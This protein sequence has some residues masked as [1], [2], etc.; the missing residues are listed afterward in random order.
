MLKRILHARQLLPGA[1]PRLFSLPPMQLVPRDSTLSVP[2]SCSAAVHLHCRSVADCR[3]GDNGKER[4]AASSPALQFCRAPLD[5][6]MQHSCI[7]LH[8]HCRSVLHH[9]QVEAAQLHYFSPALQVGPAPPE[10]GNF[11]V[12]KVKAPPKNL[13]KSP[14]T[15][16]T[17]FIIS[18]ALVFLCT[19]MTTCPKF[20]LSSLFYVFGLFSDVLIIIIAEYVPRLLTEIRKNMKLQI[21]D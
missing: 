6:W 4:S 17:F 19:G 20:F 14:I 11:R 15:C 18:G 9:R 7:I 21:C 16:F 13:E 1:S 5:R 12:K 8:L 3:T 2:S 10:K